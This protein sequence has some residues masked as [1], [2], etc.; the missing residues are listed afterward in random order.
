MIQAK[1]IE[2]FRDKQG[3][4]YGYRLV[5]LNGQTQDVT[6][7]NLKQ[8]IKNKKINVVNL[9]LTSD[10]RLMDTTPKQ[11]QSKELGKA[12]AKKEIKAVSN[13]VKSEVSDLAK[14]FTLIEW[15]YIDMGDDIEEVVNDMC[16]AAGIKENAW[17]YHTEKDVL[18]LLSRAH[19]VILNKNPMLLYNRLKHLIT[20]ESEYYIN[21]IKDYMTSEN[22][23]K[24]ND[25]KMY[26]ALS[27]IYKEVK[28]KDKQLAKIIKSEL[29]DDMKVNGVASIRVGYGIGHEYF[30]YLNREVF[31]TISN[32][33]FTVGH[34]ITAS[35]VKECKECKGYSYVFHK[36][37]NRCGAPNI[38]IAAFF[39]NTASGDIQVDLKVERHGY[40]SESRSCVTTR[41]Y[42][43]D[44][45]S[46]VIN[47]NTPIEESAKTVA[48][49]FNEIGPK[50]YDLADACQS[51]Y[52]NLDYNKPLENVSLADLNSHGKQ[53]GSLL[54]NKAIS[55]WTTIRGDKTPAKEHR[56]EY[57]SDSN[58]RILYYNN[59]GRDDTIKRL[60]V[61]YDGSK[62]TIRVVKGNNINDVIIE[63]SD[64]MSGSIVDNS[65]KFAE[66]MC[67]A[68]ISA[69]VRRI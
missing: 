20:E 68:M 27:L 4:I 36:N 51:L 59:V 55:R 42:I 6:P 54:V 16:D 46:F 64:V 26:K 11:L 58:F 40:L 12:P 49:K 53:Y 13:N 15:S 29:L 18:G 10:G 3:R 14:A 39:K 35:D 50:L 43:L 67:K 57:N 69:N 8:A 41:G 63:E 5:D 61:E 23:S 34:V 37:I 22:V 38:S 32:D 31:G 25:S 48:A 24:V 2:K 21:Q 47:K 7:E 52:S 28:D 62:L 56:S 44:I 19:Q 30:R 45:E 65:A 9:T 1:C 60:Y 33:V 17:D 66:V